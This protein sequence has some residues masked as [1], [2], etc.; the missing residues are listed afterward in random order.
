[1]QT[2][3]SKFSLQLRVACKLNAERWDESEHFRTSILAQRIFIFQPMINALSFDSV[4][5]DGDNVAWQC[6]IELRR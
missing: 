2:R 3:R 5:S 6:Y 1:M 4:Q